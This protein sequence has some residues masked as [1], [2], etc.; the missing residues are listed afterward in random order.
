VHLC[1]NQPKLAAELATLVL[2]ADDWAQDAL[3]I[4]AAVE[5]FVAAGQSDQAQHLLARAVTNGLDPSSPYLLASAGRI[6]L[7]NGDLDSAIPR[8]SEAARVGEFNRSSQHQAVCPELE[9]TDRT[10]KT[11]PPFMRVPSF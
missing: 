4:A 8:L 11:D 2:T 9:S 3:V 10:P 7:T 6:D 5:A 1:L